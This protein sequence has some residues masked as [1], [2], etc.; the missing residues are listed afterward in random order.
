MPRAPKLTTPKPVFHEFVTPEI[1]VRA[2]ITL[3]PDEKGNPLKDSWMLEFEIKQPCSTTTFISH[4]PGLIS[5]SRWR[6]VEMG[7]EG[8]SLYQGN[9]DGAIDIRDDEFIFT[10]ELSGSGGDVSFSTSVPKNMACAVLTG[11]LSDADQLGLEFYT[12]PVRT[13]MHPDDDEDEADEADEM[14][15]AAEEEPEADATP[16]ADD[17]PDAEPEADDIPDAEPEADDIP[18]AEPEADEEDAATEEDA[19]AEEDTAFDAAVEADLAEPE[20]AAEPLV[21]HAVENLAISK[22]KPVARTSKA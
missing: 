22:K 21:V 6:A 10:T 15:D 20:A 2:R 12:G 11:A 17:V 8:V 19:A 13:N 16:E 18:D 3:D 5:R 1:T 9:S 14:D 4:E 7:T